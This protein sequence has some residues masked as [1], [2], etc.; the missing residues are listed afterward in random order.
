MPTHGVLSP[1]RGTQQVRY[2]KVTSTEAI[3]NGAGK[4]CRDRAGERIQT[5][6]SAAS[7]DCT[8]DI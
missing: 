5:C 3:A 2:E 1:R 4:K 7:G 6:I 8:I